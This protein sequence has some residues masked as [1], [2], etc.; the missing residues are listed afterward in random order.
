MTN[1]VNLVK[2]FDLKKDDLFKGVN[3]L[4]ERKNKS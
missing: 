4:I 2:V 3:Q 1:V